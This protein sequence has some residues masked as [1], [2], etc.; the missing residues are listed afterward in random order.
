MT[1]RVNTRAVDL[2]FTLEG[3]AKRELGV[4]YNLLPLDERI[5]ST[6]PDKYFV[7][8]TTIQVGT[9]EQAARFL[10]TTPPFRYRYFIVHSQR[11]FGE[12]GENKETTGPPS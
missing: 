4:I 7:D 5:C 2:I 1:R 11:S 3:A 12:K 9:H 10:S 6:D 8:C